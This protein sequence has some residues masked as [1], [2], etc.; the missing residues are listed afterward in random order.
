MKNVPEPDFEDISALYLRDMAI[1]GSSADFVAETAEIEKES[2]GIIKRWDSAGITPRLRIVYKSFAAWC[3]QIGY[4]P[5]PTVNEFVRTL[6]EYHGIEVKQATVLTNH[7]ESETNDLKPPLVFLPSLGE[8][9]G[10]F[11]VD[12][13]LEPFKD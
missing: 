4:L 13:L 8:T 2:S 5:V 11:G 1:L 12:E 6:R 10:M 7:R 3:N 9:R